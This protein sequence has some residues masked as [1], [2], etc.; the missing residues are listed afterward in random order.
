[1]LV[2]FFHRL[3]LE[4]SHEPELLLILNDLVFCSAGAAVCDVDK[5]EG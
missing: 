2:L 1:M 3:L 5:E 4:P